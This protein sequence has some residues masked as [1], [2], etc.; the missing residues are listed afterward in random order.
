M[1]PFLMILWRD[2]WFKN[3]RKFIWD[4][5]PCYKQ[6]W[7]SWATAW[8]RWLNVTTDNETNRLAR[9]LWSLAGTGMQGHAPP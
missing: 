8:D 6:Q 5:S 4:D 3:L 9:L 1:H 7:T 2:K